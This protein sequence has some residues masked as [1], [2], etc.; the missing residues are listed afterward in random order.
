M[1]RTSVTCVDDIPQLKNAIKHASKFKLVFSVDIIFNC[2]ALRVCVCVN[3]TGEYLHVEDFASGQN[4]LYNKLNIFESY[5]NDFFC[6]FNTQ[7]FPCLRFSG[8]K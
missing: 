3:G 5:T 6:V 8:I 1:T 7:I 2:S 4:M